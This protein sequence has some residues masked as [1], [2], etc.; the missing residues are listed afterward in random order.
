MAT[1]LIGVSLGLAGVLILAGSAWYAYEATR[2]VLET[3]LTTGEVVDHEFT[4]GI[5]NAVREVGS[6]AT[7]RTG[8]YAPIVAFRTDSGVAIE[9]Q[10]NWSEGDPPAIGSTVPVRYHEQNPAQARIS[11]L[12]SLYGGAVILFLMG[13][14]FAGAGGLILSAKGARG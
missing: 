1:K 2:F 12:V 5:N 3:E 8:I 14:V 6:T 11:G 9:F 4:G 13:A 7:R 10:A